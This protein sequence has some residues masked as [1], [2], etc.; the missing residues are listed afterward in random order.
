MTFSA[1]ILGG[2]MDAF[3]KVHIYELP[4]FFLEISTGS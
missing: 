4:E 3:S 1:S 2:S